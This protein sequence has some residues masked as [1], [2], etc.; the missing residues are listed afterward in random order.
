MV[1]DNITGWFT[2]GQSK[3]Q[4]R[5]TLC[6]AKKLILLLTGQDASVEKVYNCISTACNSETMEKV[7]DS[8]DEQEAIAKLEEEDVSKA[9][10]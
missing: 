9:S 8:P 4:L 7:L 10:N 5:A 2:G 6:P 1:V 3:P